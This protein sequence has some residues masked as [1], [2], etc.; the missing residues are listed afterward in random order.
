[1][2]TTTRDKHQSEN[3]PS[4]PVHYAWNEYRHGMVLDLPGAS[5]WGSHRAA[6]PILDLDKFDVRM[7]RVPALQSSP[8][9]VD[10]VNLLVVQVEGEIEFYANSHTL[11]LE[12]YDLL[13]VPEGTEYC[14]M[15]VG[16]DDTFFFAIAGKPAAGQPSTRNVGLDHEL[17]S[18]RWK[19]YRRK[20]NWNISD[21]DL[22]GYH[23]GTYPGLETSDVSL[24]MVVQPGWQSSNI[25]G[26]T[27][28]CVFLQ[29]KGETL[30]E[31]GPSPDHL[32]PYR[33]QPKD[34]LWVPAGNPYRYTTVGSSPSLFVSMATQWGPDAKA[35]YYD[36]RPR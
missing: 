4:N 16:L 27:W 26:K 8:T 20:I 2:A 10:A 17:A 25:H 29:M 23:R 21:A 5:A 15:N 24:H 28:D 32:K 13:R 14:Y 33:L 36:R 6:Y 30:F 7:I 1:M 18:L 31:T 12:P 3:N 9:T 34:V 22:W 35:T 19:E 11:P